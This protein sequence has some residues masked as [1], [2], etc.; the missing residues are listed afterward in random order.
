MITSHE[1]QEYS[2]KR[3][4][5]CNVNNVENVLTK[6]QCITT[7]NYSGKFIGSTI[8]PCC[9]VEF[10]LSV[11]FSQTSRLDL[12]ITINSPDDSQKSSLLSLL[13]NK[14]LNLQQ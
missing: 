2:A 13:F 4:S 1:N 5:S 3:L 7:K 8:N 14:D 12:N 9:G 6:T 10:T 11:K